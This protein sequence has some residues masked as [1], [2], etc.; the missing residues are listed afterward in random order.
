MTYFKKLMGERIYLSPLNPDDAEILTAWAND[1]E[2]TVPLG[3]VEAISMQ[4]EREI[5]QHLAKADHNFSIV[6][7]DLD[8][9][10]MIG[11]GGFFDVDHRDR[12]AMLT[13]RI[14]DPESRG[15][16]YG[17]EAINLMLE[18]GFG[19]LNLENILL[20]VASYN[21]R[22]IRCYE[23]C[24]FKIMGRRRNAIWING[25][26]YDNVYMDIIREDFNKD[27]RDRLP[28]YFDKA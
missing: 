17:T 9:D 14:G 4:R 20:T 12:R 26:A 18:Y 15:K 22:A 23:K 16:G 21:T 25:E 13:I 2:T 8:E 7:H 5:L 10:K 11:N 28:I 27:I 6:R 24:G 19:L 1:L 3:H